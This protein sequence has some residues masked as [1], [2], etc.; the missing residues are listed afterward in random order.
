MYSNTAQMPHA[1][2]RRSK[3]AYK[4]ASLEGG[5]SKEADTA[6]IRQRNLQRPAHKAPKGILHAGRGKV[7][8]EKRPY[9]KKEN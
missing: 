5:S 7:K 1:L 9:G 3:N 6:R 4:K 2:R 8:G